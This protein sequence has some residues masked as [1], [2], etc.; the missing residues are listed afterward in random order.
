MEQEKKSRPG[1]SW[2]SIL[3]FVVGVGTVAGVIYYFSNRDED[4]GSEEISEPPV[5]KGSSTALWGGILSALG[6]LVLAGM[7]LFAG[8][9]MA[10]ED[11]ERDLFEEH[12]S[13]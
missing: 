11:S 10:H 4:K 2:V 12:E 1:W 9:G 6:G 7:A 3:L 8:R 13:K 5:Y